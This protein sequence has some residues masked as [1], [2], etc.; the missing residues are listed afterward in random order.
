MND[1]SAKR[2][3]A[4][5][6]RSQIESKR[7]MI[8]A[9]NGSAFSL[10]HFVNPIIVLRM[11]SPIFWIRSGAYALSAPIA[12]NA[13]ATRIKPTGSEK[14][15]SVASS[16]PPIDL[17]NPTTSGIS[18]VFDFTNQP[19]NTDPM[20]PSSVMMAVFISS[21]RSMIALPMSAMPVTNAAIP[22]PTMNKPA[23]KT[24]NAAP[25]LINVNVIL[26]PAK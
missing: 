15:A 3:S 17:T 10:I 11:K 14:P 21:P 24:T 8:A 7:S 23:P 9:A 16:F 6:I 25:S 5:I 19:A 12:A 20:M 2:P 18:V 4:S 1:F 26:P 13:T 22:L